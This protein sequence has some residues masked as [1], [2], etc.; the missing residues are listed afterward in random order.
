VAALF[1]SAFDMAAVLSMSATFLYL[2]YRSQFLVKH[3]SLSHCCLNRALAKLRT[4]RGLGQP[5]C[6]PAA[7]RRFAPIGCCLHKKLL[8]LFS[9]FAN[10]FVKCN[11]KAVEKGSFLL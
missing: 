7:Y 5:L 6:S 9:P 8:D 11:L 10:I 3:Q 1:L 2:K 4:S